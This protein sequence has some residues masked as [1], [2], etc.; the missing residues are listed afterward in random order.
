MTKTKFND[1]LK[2]WYTD[3]LG[4]ITSAPVSGS[5]DELPDGY[6][7]HHPRLR[8]L[9]VS[10]K[11]DIL[12]SNG[13]CEACHA[14]LLHRS[15][16]E[17]IKAGTLVEQFHDGLIIASGSREILRVVFVDHETLTAIL[18]TSVPGIRLSK[19]EL[20]LLMQMLCGLSLRQ[21]S[22]VDNVAYET[23]R[24]QFKAI[25]VRTGFKTQTE[26][27][28]KTLLAINR[29][30][31]ETTSSPRPKESGRQNQPE[32]F[33][34]RYY[35]GVFR[36]CRITT[37]D[38]KSLWVAETGPTTG[39]PVVCLH[40]Q[41]LPPPEQFLT[42]WTSQENIRLIIPFRDGFL[43]EVNN[44]YDR[45]K[46]LRQGTRDIVQTID[47]FC[48]GCAHIVANSTG[49]PYAVSVAV[50]YP[51]RVKRLTFCAAAYV[52][53]YT[54][55]PVRRLT[56]GVKNL[57]SRNEFLIA[58]MFE[59]YLLKMSTPAG[60]LGILKSAY[61]NSPRDMALFI[62]LTSNPVSH[63]WIYESYR[64]SRNSVIMDIAMSSYD[65]WQNA[66]KIRCPVLFVHGRS[67][68]INS[69]TDARKVADLIPNSQFVEIEDEGQSLFISRL[70]QV[71][72]MGG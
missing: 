54:N 57:F 18:Q 45:E 28:R 33:L 1:K 32:D 49:S 24:S 27:V 23:K 21:A 9:I 19:S 6:H 29:D 44:P 31:L 8:L 58:K 2:L 30:V 42:D 14:F 66:D 36:I 62:A 26:V 64:M 60:M 53:N 10:F 72:L 7:K 68:P 70:C 46:H 39:T 16:G 61:H 5:G 15:V 51:D 47:F 11:G 48:N 43:R 37:V 59:H 35:P 63:S 38:G 69:V 56:S 34:N 22:E 67:D 3:S 20:H 40:S 12:M 4:L 25:A 17:I 13:K 71:V 65:V 50:N 41:T 52:G 55:Q